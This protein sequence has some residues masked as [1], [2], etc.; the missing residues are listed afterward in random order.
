MRDFSLTLNYYS[1]RAYEY[2]RKSLCLP[3][4]S[5][6]RAITSSVKCLPGFQSE[7]FNELKVLAEKD[8][9]YQDA[10]L[11][12]DGMS[13]KEYSEY[14]PH[15]QRTFGMVDYGG[16]QTL[17][18]GDSRANEVLTCMLVGLRKYWKL[19]ISYV[20]VR[21]V[22]GGVLSGIIRECLLQSMEAGVKVWTL[23]MDGTSHNIS[24]CQD[25]GA[26]IL[27]SDINGMEAS[28]RHPTASHRV[29]VI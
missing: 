27:T 20:L 5:T 12:I 24:A 25:L 18:E 13:I 8:I 1:P 3:H 29:S 21:S 22:S 14:D 23:T 4:P 19:P 15:L 16:N 2:L 10:A 28:F 17:N 11:I 7:S 6:L 26:K 9:N